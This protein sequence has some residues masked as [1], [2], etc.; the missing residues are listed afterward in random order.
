MKK[1]LCLLMLGLL[2]M[3]VVAED[4]MQVNPSG[5]PAPKS[6]LVPPPDTVDPMDV[7]CGDVAYDGV[8]GYVAQRRPD[9]LEAW[10]MINCEFPE[11]VEIQGFNWVTVD[12]TDGDWAGTDD[13]AIWEASTVENGCADDSNTVAAGRDL[14]N[15]RQGPIDFLFGRNAWRYTL[16]LPD[17]VTLPA[18]KY[19]FGVRAVT[20]SGQSFILT[21]PL[22]GRKETWFVS[23]FFGFPC[24]VPASTLFGAPSSNAIEVLGKPAGPPTPRCIYQVSK[25]KNKANLCGTVCDTCPYVRGDL[26]CTNECRDSN[27][28]ASRLRGFNACPNGAACKVS[29]DLVGCDIPP[30]DC[31]R[32][33]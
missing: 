18:G 9:G 13:F 14:T 25:V 21:T 19:Y 2:A 5:I 7:L 10:T 11:D 16:V 26:I 1:M 20:V 23:A 15:T 24:A 27:D 8:N 32:C 12:N 30:R 31:K 4:L 3:P 6:D 29:A 22:N 17:P 28:C 33:R